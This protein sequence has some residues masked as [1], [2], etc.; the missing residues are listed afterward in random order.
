MPPT[1]IDL[2][3]VRGDTLSLTAT[4]YSATGAV[5]NLTGCTLWFTLKLSQD[6]AADDTAAVS[7]CSWVSGGAASGIAVAS[8]AT[9][10]LTIDAPAADTANL[11]PALTYV[12]DIQIKDANA[13]IYTLATGAVTAA[14]DITRRLTTP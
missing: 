14:P 4:A 12:Y 2:A 6:D 3:A 1:I 8:P 11:D 9:G 5:L 13:R 10:V 7:R